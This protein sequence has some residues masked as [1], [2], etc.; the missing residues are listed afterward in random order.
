MSG[1]IFSYIYLVIYLFPGPS[2]GVGGGSGNGKAEGAAGAAKFVEE[3][4]AAASCDAHLKPAEATAATGVSLCLCVHMS[5]CVF[6]C[7]AF[8]V[9]CYGLGFRVGGNRHADCGGIFF[10]TIGY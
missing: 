9:L 10:C 5:L 1:D 6:V 7:S 3:M 4:G 8:G 2:A